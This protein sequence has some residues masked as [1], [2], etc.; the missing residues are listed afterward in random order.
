MK[1]KI[2]KKAINNILKELGVSVKKFDIKELQDGFSVELEHGKKNK[3]TNLTNNDPKLTL[4][5]V[6]AHLYE[7][8]HYYE[9]LLKAGL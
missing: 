6:L 4:M 3:L 8:P 5:I 1:K 7:D 2:T 9:K